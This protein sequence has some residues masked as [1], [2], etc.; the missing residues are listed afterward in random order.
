MIG[1]ILGLPARRRVVFSAFFSV[2]EVHLKYSSS[3]GPF[4]FQVGSDRSNNQ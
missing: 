1:F 3:N 4:L 2:F